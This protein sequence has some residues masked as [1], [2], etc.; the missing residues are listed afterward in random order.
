MKSEKVTKQELR[1]V[2]VQVKPIGETWNR[3]KSCKTDA[4]WPWGCR[5]GKWKNVV[6]ASMTTNR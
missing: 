1:A 3:E 6:L 5:I 4:M 2:S